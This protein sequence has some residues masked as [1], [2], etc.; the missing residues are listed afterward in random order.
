MRVR[1]TR[2][3]Q[4]DLQRI[5]AYVS[6]RDPIAASRLVTQIVDRAWELGNV[7]HEGRETDEPNARVLVLPRLRYLVFYMIAGDELQITHVR[8]A[9]RRRPSGWQR[10]P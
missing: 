6:Q 4:A 1:F 9:S 2:P 10:R 3:A 7:P 5:H 8:H